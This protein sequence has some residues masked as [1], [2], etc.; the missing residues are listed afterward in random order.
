MK[1]APNP[2]GARGPRKAPGT[3]QRLEPLRQKATINLRKPRR[4]TGEELTRLIPIDAER[5]TWLE[6]AS[7]LMTWDPENWDPWY[8]KRRRRAKA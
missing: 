6:A 3:R 8:P 2:P 7:I 5:L 4:L 1:R